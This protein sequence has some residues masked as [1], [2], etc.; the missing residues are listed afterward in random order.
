MISVDTIQLCHF[1]E[2]TSITGIYLPGEFLTVV[3]LLFFS[4]RIKPTIH[5][6]I[7][8]KN[9]THLLV[10]ERNLYDTGYQEAKQTVSIAD[11]NYSF[12]F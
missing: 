3:V 6:K 5:F 8:L 10:C 9:L 7:A 12:L 1:V 2:F 4:T 11:V